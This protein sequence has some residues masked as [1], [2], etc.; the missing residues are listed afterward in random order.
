[1]AKKNLNEAVKLLTPTIQEADPYTPAEWKKIKKLS[2]EKGKIFKD[3][4]SLRNYLDKA[5]CNSARK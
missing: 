5:W 3:A 4:K 1:M 2:A